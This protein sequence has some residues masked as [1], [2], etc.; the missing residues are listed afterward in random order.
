MADEKSDFRC[1]IMGQIVLIRSTPGSANLPKVTYA[2]MRQLRWHQLPAPAEFDISPFQVKVR[3]IGIVRI[4]PLGDI[5]TQADVSRA[6]ADQNT[7]AS[8]HQ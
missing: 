5:R 6:A 7:T 8:D 3:D 4:E 1:M 2:G